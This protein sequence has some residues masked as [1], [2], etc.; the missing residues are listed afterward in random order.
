MLKRRLSM[1]TTRTNRLAALALCSAL[2]VGCK[3]K[4]PAPAP[5]PQSDDESVA[6]LLDP[7]PSALPSAG[8]APSRCHELAGKSFTIGEIGKSRAPAEDEE[9][10][11]PDED[12]EVPAP[13]SVERFK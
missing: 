2:V 5:E 9:E 3:K 12:D 1:G 6:P 11:G 7:A 8:P 4:P 10:A 13:F